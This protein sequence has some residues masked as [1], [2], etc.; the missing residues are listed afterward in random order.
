MKIALSIAPPYGEASDSGSAAEPRGCPPSMDEP[1]NDHTGP[2]DLPRLPFD[3]QD[4]LDVPAAYRALQADEP[5]ARVRTATGDVAWLVSGYEEARQ[6]FADRRLG[7][8]AP[9]PDRAARISNSVILGGPIGD[10]ET[11][12]TQHERMRRLLTPV[13][14]ARRMAA[15]APHV[16]E[17]VD[18]LLDRMAEGPRPADLRQVLS[19]PLP[20]LVICELLGVPYGDREHFRALAETMTDLTDRERSAAALT[21]LGEYTRKIIGAKR[22]NPAGDVFSDLATMDA[23]DEEIATLAAGLLFAGHETTVNRI[24]YGVL[25]LLANPGQRDALI[26]DPSLV[27]TAVEEILRVA[28]PGNHGMPRYAHEDVTV[29]GVTIRRGEAVVIST[30]AANRDA[31]V[32]ADPDRFDVSRDTDDPHLAFGYAARYCIGASLARIELRAVF[33]T[34]FQR[35]PTLALAVPAEELVTRENSLTGGFEGIPVTW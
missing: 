13:F 22:E 1:V 31:R 16:Q 28:A 21:E 30:T 2:D 29:G 23:P 33:G 24:D 14:S 8:S 4:P 12:K 34:L 18:G 7:R 19:L 10:I 32:F 15:L 27:N 9:D 5:V 20:V 3:R 35:F 17:L 25:L 11:E 6:A 26:A